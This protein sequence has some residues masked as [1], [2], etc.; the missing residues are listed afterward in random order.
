MVPQNPTPDTPNARAVCRFCLKRIALRAD[1]T[2]RHHT[3]D[4]KPRHTW[5][6][7][8]WAPRC[9]GAGTKPLNGGT[10]ENGSVR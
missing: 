10:G 1:G 4:L 5:E 8:I 9:E 2:F 7:G 3:N 6:L